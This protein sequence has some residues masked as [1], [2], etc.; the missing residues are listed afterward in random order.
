ML[1]RSNL[2]GSP[3]QNPSGGGAVNPQPEP[4]QDGNDDGRNENTTAEFKE[5]NLNTEVPAETTEPESESQQ[6]GKPSEKS[7]EEEDEQETISPPPIPE[8]ET[9]L[10][11]EQIHE[12]PGSVDSTTAIEHTKPAEAATTEEYGPG[13]G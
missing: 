11:E 3:Q 1:F 12:G 13:V 7:S 8:T 9:T 4:A 10:S 6:P 2:S 5:E